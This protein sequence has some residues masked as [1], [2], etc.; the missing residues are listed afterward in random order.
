MSVSISDTFRTWNLTDLK[1]ECTLEIFHHVELLWNG[2][3]TVFLNTCDNEVDFWLGQELLLGLRGLRG[4]LREVNNEVPANQAN[5]NSDYS[6]QNEDPAPPGESGTE[7]WDDLWVLL[8]GACI[9]SCQSE[10]H[11]QDFLLLTEML[12]KVWGR[13][14]TMACEE[15]EEVS[16]NA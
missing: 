12:S 10:T 4:E 13:L 14:H 2:I 8:G 5:D 7:V 1:V 16:E 11:A 9:A 3:V 6:L 15:G